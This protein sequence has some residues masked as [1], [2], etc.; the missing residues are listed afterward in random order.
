MWPSSEVGE[1]EVQVV[2]FGQGVEV[3]GVEFEDVCCVEGAEGC[4][5]GVLVEGLFW[6]DLDGLVYAEKA[7]DMK[8]I[9]VMT[10][11][12]IGMVDR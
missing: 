8:F 5:F 11:I 3:G 6:Y 12:S 9:D 1:V 10:V 7:V 2:G 4:H